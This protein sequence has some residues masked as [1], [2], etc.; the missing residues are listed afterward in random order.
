MKHTGQES[1][2]ELCKISKFWSFLQPVP[3]TTIGASPLDPTRRLSFPRLPWAASGCAAELSEVNKQ[4]MYGDVRAARRCMNRVFNDYGIFHFVSQ[5]FDPLTAKSSVDGEVQ[6]SV[7]DL[8]K[9]IST[10][11]LIHI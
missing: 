5:S 1:G 3:Q 2:G 9:R 8:I 7:D 10:L 4:Y 6:L 11:S